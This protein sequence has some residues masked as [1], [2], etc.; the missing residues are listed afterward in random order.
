MDWMIVALVAL[1][2]DLVTTE[3]GLRAGGREL[4]RLTK[5]RWARYGVNAALLG[6]MFV[7]LNE[8]VAW[9]AFGAVHLLA[10]GWNVYQLVK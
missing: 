2:L 6:I 10:A 4:N 1:A 8:P 3:L 7:F 5:S 9:Q